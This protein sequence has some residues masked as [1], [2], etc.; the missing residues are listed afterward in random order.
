MIIDEII[1]K[2]APNNVFNDGISS[3]IKYPNPIAKTR[4][5]YFK[6]VLMIPQLIYRIDLTTNLQGPQIHQLKLIKLSR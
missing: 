4:A 2:A 1:T 3:Q 5:K 6:G